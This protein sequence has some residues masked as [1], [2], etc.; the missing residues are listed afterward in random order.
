MVRKC[1][2]CGGKIQVVVYSDHTY[3]GGNCFTRAFPEPKRGE[4]SKESWEC[5]KC[6]GPV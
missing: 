5:E 3:F 6:W 4:K 1:E 2:V